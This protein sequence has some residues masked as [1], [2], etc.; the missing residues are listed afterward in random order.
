M[1]A[2]VTVP[3]LDCVQFEGLWMALLWFHQQKWDLRCLYKCCEVK[4]ITVAVLREEE[5]KNIFQVR[6]LLK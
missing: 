2:S 3:Q 6:G 5:E 1:E 4:L